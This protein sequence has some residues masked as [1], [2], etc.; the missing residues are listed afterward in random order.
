MS[1]NDNNNACAPNACISGSLSSGED[2]ERGLITPERLKGA[3]S[4]GEA[5]AIYNE[6]KT[7]NDFAG[8]ARKFMHHDDYQVARNALWGLTKATDS[9]LSQLQ[10]MLHEFIDL[11]LQTD[12]SSVRRLSLN[13]VERLKIDEDDL[14][15]DFYDFCLDHMTDV[16]EFPGIQSLCMKIGYRMSAFYPELM[17][18]FV[19][20][21]EMM[22]M[23]Y[24]KPAVRSVRNRIMSGKMKPSRRKN[25]G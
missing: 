22:E 14:R 16:E 9:E 23:D 1:I 24:Y 18:E 4:E 3:Y 11:A 20:T 6:V 10:P 7:L 13:I 17:G 2:G 5:L 12:N 15:T 19:R 8:F 25:M 21:V